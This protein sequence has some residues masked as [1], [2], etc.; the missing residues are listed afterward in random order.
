MVAS[1][2]A[3]TIAD[4]P[5]GICMDSI[6]GM[7]SGYCAL[8]ATCAHGGPVCNLVATAFLQTSE[9]AD[10]AI[11]NAGGCKTS[12]AAGDFTSDVASAILPNQHELVELTMNGEDIK[13]MLNDVV[14]YSHQDEF[15]RGAYPYAAGVRF[16]VDMTPPGNR[17]A[18][19]H[20]IS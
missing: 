20:A 1:V 16:D 7:G 2:S 13:T 15:K 19:R 5:F 17:R 4:V 12:V 14:A 10:I 18:C 3:Q 9:Q 11:Q 8:D 6:P